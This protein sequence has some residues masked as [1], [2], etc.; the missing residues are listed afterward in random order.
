MDTTC[1]FVMGT[2]VSTAEGLKAMNKLIADAGWLE[3]ASRGEDEHDEAWRCHTS[4]LE[5][6][7][8]LNTE[9]L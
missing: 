8:V 4:A 3:V 2:S 5:G 9:T 1:S 7:Q 6:A